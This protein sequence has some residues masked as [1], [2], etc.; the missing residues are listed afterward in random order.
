VLPRLINPL[1]IL[2]LERNIGLYL[3]GVIIV[4][5]FHKELAQVT[6]S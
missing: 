1:L 5:W 2:H 4:T 3:W 6:K